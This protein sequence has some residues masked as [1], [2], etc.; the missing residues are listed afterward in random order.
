MK[1]IGGSLY[2]RKGSSSW[3]IKFYVP[4]NP[5]P[6]RESAK[7]DSEKEAAKVLKKRLGEVATGTFSAGDPRVR[8]STLLDLFI[9]DQ[10]LRQRKG[11]SKARSHEKRIREFFGHYRPEQVGNSLIDEFILRRQ[12]EKPKTGQGTIKNATINRELEILRRAYKLGFNHEPQLVTRQIRVP[13]LPENNVREGYL[14]H[15]DYVKLRGALPAH[16]RLLLICGYHLGTRLGELCQVEWSRVN[17]DRREILLPRAT[18]KNDKPRI[19]PIYG[20]MEK[21]LQAEKRLQEDRYPSCRWVFQRDGY[22][23]TF[24]WATW[25]KLVSEAGV[26]GFKFHDLRR[27]AVTNMI[28]AG[29]PE[30]DAMEISGHTTRKMLERYHIIRRE[31]IQRVGSTMEKVFA[32]KELLVGTTAGT[33]DRLAVGM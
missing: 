5:N 13:R 22:Q 3:W 23:L 11:L 6:V 8:V 20:E 12:K 17:F 14:S 4:G 18:A 24:R 32:G 9:K 26:T 15:E 16:Y 19:V 31:T 21:A 10:E 33:E 29:I 28:D 7:T 2:R 30:K 25:N 1:N 27:T